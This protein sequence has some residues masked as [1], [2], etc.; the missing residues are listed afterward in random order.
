MKC[1][2]LKISESK[3]RYITIMLGIIVIIVG[4]HSIVNYTWYDTI[5]CSV[6]GG[7]YIIW[8]GYLET[9]IIRKLENTSLNDT[10]NI[11]FSDEG[12]YLL[13]EYEEKI[14]TNIAENTN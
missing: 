6:V 7:G 10:M 12:K 4:L 9:S 14:E 5:L 2:A 11:S 13:I 3:N 8:S 1:I